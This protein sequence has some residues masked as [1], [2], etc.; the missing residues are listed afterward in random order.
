MDGVADVFLDLVTH[1]PVDGVADFGVDVF[2][3]IT[4]HGGADISVDIFTDFVVDVSADLGWLMNAFLHFDDFADHCCLLIAGSVDV[5]ALAA[6]HREAGADLFA[7]FLGNWDVVLC[8]DLLTDLIRD[9]L[10]DLFLDFEA[11]LHRDFGAFLLSDGAA[12]LLWD[13]P[14]LLVLHLPAVL[15]GDL[16]AD[17]LINWVAD[18]LGVRRADFTWDLLTLGDLLADLVLHV[19]ADLFRNRLTDF[20]V[21]RAAVFLLGNEFALLARHWTAFL[22]CNL[23]TLL[24]VDGVAD[25]LWLVF[26]LLYFWTLPLRRIRIGNTDLDVI[27]HLLVRTESELFVDAFVTGFALSALLVGTS[28]QRSCVKPRRHAQENKG[29]EELGCAH[30]LK[31]FL[32]SSRGI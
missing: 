27:A 11:F 16:L 2:T 8:G 24:N 21:F 30:S 10:A 15:L 5:G 28:E 12:D 26:T 23:L 6:D 7:D 19:V 22:L 14:A 4:L 31:V 1:F 32:S 25:L 9:V 18:F 29:H 3:V 17:L 13:S 20:L